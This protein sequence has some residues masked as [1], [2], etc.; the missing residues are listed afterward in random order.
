MTDLAPLLA[1]AAVRSLEEEVALSPKPGLVDP[2]SVGA[3]DD[4]DLSTFAASIAA[5]SPYFLVYIRLGA[6]PGSTN[7]VYRRV[8]RTGLEAEEAM[9]QATGGV[10]THKGINFLLGFL[11][12]GFGRLSARFTLQELV[13]WNFSPLFLTAASLSAY[14]TE[15]FSNVPEDG[16][17]TYGQRL[18]LSDGVKGVRGEITAGCPTL[19][20][21]VLPYLSASTDRGDVRYLRLMLELMGHLEDTNILHRGGPAGLSWVRRRAAA[22]SGVGDKELCR[23]LRA[24]DADMIRRHLSPGGTAD[25]LALGYFFDH[26]RAAASQAALQ[27][28][29]M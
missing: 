23:C 20:T 16:Q 2:C 8:R 4:M 29:G 6:G 24:M 7:Q 9:L 18:F 11:L 14:V 25:F 27:G 5:L 1:D 21:L 26:L 22:L 15:D 28:I 17:L 12:A 13:H 3:H 19:R 10:N